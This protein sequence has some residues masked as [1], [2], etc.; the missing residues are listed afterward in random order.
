MPGACSRCGCALH[1]CE[2]LDDVDAVRNMTFDEFKLI[3]SSY[4]TNPD[5]TV[6]RWMYDDRLVAAQEADVKPKTSQER[7]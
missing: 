7:N 6:L 4:F 1:E 2:C 3:V 5:E